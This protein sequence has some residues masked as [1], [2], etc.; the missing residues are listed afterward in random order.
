MVLDD[1]GTARV[2]RV[3]ERRRPG[4]RGD[5]GDGSGRDLSLGDDRVDGDGTPEGCGDSHAPRRDGRHGVG[6][7]TT[8]RVNG[9]FVVLDTDHHRA[10]AVR[11]ENTS[12][13]SR[14]PVQ[15]RFRRMAIGITHPG[16]GNRDPRSHGVEERLGRGRLAPMVGDLEQI[17]TRQTLGQ[18]L[19]VDRLLDVAHQQ[20]AAAPHLAEQDN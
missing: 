20:E 16:R 10:V 9:H 3:A 8:L 12:P 18:Q 7:P 11:S 15:R 4:D 14:Q 5:G 13:G 19:R 6:R 2:R 1:G 17:D